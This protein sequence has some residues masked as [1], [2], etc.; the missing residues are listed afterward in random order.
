MSVLR[1]A[2]RVIRGPRRS[3]Y[4]PANASFKRVAAI[5]SAILDHPVTAQDVAM[6][7]VGLKMVRQ[8]TKHKRDNI[9]DMAGYVGLMEQL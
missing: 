9:V 7:M 1:K 5:W 2:E 6:C 3:S 4:G 8:T